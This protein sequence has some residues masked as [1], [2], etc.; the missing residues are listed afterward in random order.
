MK[1]LQFGIIGVGRF[2][3]HYVRLLADL[4]GVNLKSTANNAAEARKLI[5]DPAIDCVI[6]ATPTT[7]HFDL[8][9]TAIGQGKHVLVEKPMVATAA[10]AGLIQSALAN[11]PVTFMVGFQYVYN[12]YIRYLRELIQGDSLGKILYILGE[13]LYCGPIRADVGCFTDA[14]AHELSILRYLFN[15]GQV[16]EVTGQSLHFGDLVHDDFTAATVSFDGGLTAHL[17]ASRFAPQKTMRLTIVGER[18]TVVFDDMKTE[19]KI[20]IFNHSYPATD[21]FQNSTKSIA[22]ESAVAVAPTIA[23]GEA[24]RNQLE[25]FVQCVRTGEQPITNIDFG[26]WVAE[27]TESVLKNVRKV[28]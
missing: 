11:S 25:H 13:H 12:D 1:T 4:P 27:Q 22:V 26:S 10:E 21:G 5:R 3:K 19:E 23:A 18:A 16:K 14:C 17:V 2:G 9:N 20:S 8:I 15:P 7:T 28:S 24:L 6:I